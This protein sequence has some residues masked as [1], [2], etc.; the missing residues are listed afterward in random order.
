LHR[1]APFLLSFLAGFLFSNPVYAQMPNPTPP[2]QAVGQNITVASGTFDI[3]SLP[4]GFPAILSANGGTITTASPGLTLNGQGLLGADVTNGG[5]III[6][7]NST[8]NVGGGLRV[9]TGGGTIE[10]TNLT[11]VLSPGGANG[12]GAQV[13]GSMIT[14]HGG[15]ITS[16]PGSVPQSTG[17]LA[18]NGATLIADGTNI[19]GS[20]RNSAQATALGH[21]E[22]SNLSITQNHVS[23]GPAFGAL[24]TATGGTITAD[25]VKITTGQPLNRGAFVQGGSI[26]LT[27]SMVTTTADSSN[28]VRAEVGF[29][30]GPGTIDADNTVITTS[31]QGSHGAIAVGAPINLATLNLNGSMVTT[32]GANANG[33]YAFF[34]ATLNAS[35]STV[36]AQ[37]ATANAGQVADQSVMN[38]TDSKLTGGANGIR[39]TDDVHDLG[40]NTLTVSRSTITATAAGAGEA[41]FRV[42]GAKANITLDSV[43]VNPGAQN[44]LL[45]VTSV[46]LNGAPF[47]S[48]VNFTVNPSTLNGDILVDAASTANVFLEHSSTLNGAVNENSLTGATGI[49]PNEPAVNLQP[50]TVNLSI[51]GTSTWNMRASSTLNTLDVSPKARVSFADP[52]ANPFKTL[53]MNNLTGTGGI[54]KLNNDLAAI[55]GDLINILN[56]SQGGHLV[57]F[58]NRTAGSDLPVDTALLVVKTT[59]GHAVFGGAEEGG[60]FLYFVRRGNGSSITPV[61]TD[62]YLVRGDEITP[63]PTPA[64]PGPQPSPSPIIPP[65]VLPPNIL[66]PGRIS[67]IDDITPGANA[68]IGTFAATMPLFYADMGTLIE[69]M[70]ELRLQAQEAPPPTTP[71]PSGI[72]KEGGKE[73]VAPHRPWRRPPVV[74]YGFA[75]LALD[76]I[77]M[78]KSAGPSIRTSEV[79]RSEQTSVWS[80]VTEIYI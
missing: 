60:T 62:W 8:F 9:S 75:A 2:V 30:G 21:I 47:G 67:R 52:P 73:V 42:D 22:L 80:P 39:I 24:E 79:F 64:P 20:F 69:R 15:S 48:V 17:V 56:S 7:D 26:L 57:L 65:D 74:E 36:S 50:Q 6:N 16:A 11:I 5:T 71:I 58:N 28:G 49:N 14:L 76:L 55:K 1:Y 44:L 53:V 46:D 54:F 68:A 29:D 37:A 40:P 34:E 72:S 19:S 38:I 3:T 10:A 41:A 25:N 12:A 43:T 78:T 77:S 27:N 51:D 4:N 32:T 63:P 18:E 31:G 13:A 33:I 59:D 23:S 35:N 70:G 61:T 45:N 66:P